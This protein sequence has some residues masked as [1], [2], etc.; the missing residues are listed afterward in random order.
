[1][2]SNKSNVCVVGVGAVGMELLR[3][4]EGRRFPIKKLTVLARSARTLKV[5]GNSVKVQAISPEAF[6]GQDLV[7]F[8]G[9]EGEQGAA[10]TFAPEAIRRGAVCID[11]G[12][13]FR[14]DPK[15]PLVIPEINPEDLQNHKGLIANPN[16]STIQMAMAL[17]P[18][19]SQRKIRKVIVST[20]Q[21]A[22]GAGQAA[23]DE[24]KS[25]TS[26]LLGNETVPTAQVLPAQIGFNAIPQIGPFQELGYT[27]EEWKI[28]KE[29]QK[30]F[31]DPALKIT[32]TTVRIPV[33]T[34]HSESVYVEMDKPIS[35]EEAKQL[36]NKA[37][38]IQVTDGPDAYP[39]PSDAAGRDEVFIGR[40]REDPF[41]RNALLFWVVSDNLRKG[42]ALNAVQIA[43]ELVK[44]AR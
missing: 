31:H 1:M 35:P 36:W 33:V 30:I 24:L 29:T 18:L 11:N 2:S 16:C 12:A 14:L 34:G 15:V 23:V 26:A 4:L 8:A 19:R 28:V 17:H 9:T 38:G 37:P 20:Y 5:E 22:S 7:L 43:E 3:V 41:D 42:A 6:E 39:M 10:V 44:G 32:A 25:Q 21:A 40:I 13:D 27:S